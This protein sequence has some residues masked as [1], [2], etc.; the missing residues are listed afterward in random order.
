MS[1]AERLPLHGVRILDLTQVW[2][3][4]K[5]TL[6][7]A[8]LGA[9]VIKVE[10]PS[11]SD[12]VRGAPGVIDYDR[13]PNRD[14]GARRY[15]RASTFNLLNRG[16]LGIN[17]DLRTAAGIDV[18]KRLVAVS[19]VVSDNFSAT[20]MTRLGLGYDVLRSIRAD[21]IMLS[22]PGFGS[23]GPERDNI[24]WADTVEAMAGFTQRTGYEDGRP[25]Y[26]VQAFPDPFSGVFGA[27]AVLTALRHR[28]RTGKGQRIEM[29][30]Q[31][32]MLTMQAEALLEYQVNG[33]TLGPRGNSHAGMAP[34]GIYPCVGDDEWV[35]IS[36]HD[37]RAWQA[38]CTA[39]GAPEWAVEARFATV[40]G[41]IRAREE[42]D[43]GLAGWT[44][45][46]DSAA[47]VERLQ[48]RGVTCGRVL[49]VGQLAQD[50]HLQERGV[51]D[52]VEHPD[53]GTHPYPRAVPFRVGGRSLPSASPAPMFGEHIQ[54]VLHDILGLSDAE[55]AQL[56]EQGVVADAP[57]WAAAEKASVR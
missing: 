30:Q 44:R 24:S 16:K 53:A 26:S 37:D 14:P 35:A 25:M 57:T 22:M 6:I 42:V 52:V 17:L 28:R 33:R 10:S 29:A 8:G 13:V 23:F 39:M 9:E 19:D 56:Y 38:L 34:H 54:H 5:C 3:G 27:A 12:I 4:S 20:V 41:R 31:E 21:I 47:L 51:F 1:A 15:N 18:F 45:D 11:R 2:A 7:L 48:A 43:L 40:L 36:V 32:A 50:R 49:S 46:Y 55:I